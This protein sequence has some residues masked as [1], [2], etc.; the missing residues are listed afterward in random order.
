MREEKER[1]EEK[2]S[3]EKKIK[4]RGGNRNPFQMTVEKKKA[5]KKRRCERREGK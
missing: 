5:K 3:I 2:E 1:C 4:V